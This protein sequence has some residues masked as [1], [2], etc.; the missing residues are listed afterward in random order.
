MKK[1]W[2]AEQDDRLR[3]M[4]AQGASNA[5]IAAALNRK[6][7]VV[8]IRARAL[9]VTCHRSLNSEEHCGTISRIE[10]R[11]KN[12]RVAK[13]GPHSRGPFVRAANTSRLPNELNLKA[14][15]SDVWWTRRFQGLGD[16]RSVGK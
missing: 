2:T 8:R 1:V 9:H 11:E 5:R 7:Q 15:L 10:Q 16:Q 14:I 12:R 4:V 3:E 6:M 13:K